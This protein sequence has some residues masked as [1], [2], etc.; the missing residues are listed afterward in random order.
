MV[1]DENYE[2]IKVY[3]LSCGHLEERERIVHVEGHDAIP[4]KS[5]YE[6]VKHTGFVKVIDSP[7]IP[8]VVEHDEVESVTVYVQDSPAD[9]IRRRRE[10]ICFPVINRGK[11]WY[12]LLTREQEDEL[13]AWYQKWL[14]APESLTEP[15]TPEWLNKKIIKTEELL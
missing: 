3:D 5:H 2:E 15:A 11:A 7:E 13:D 8:A 9:I 12:K 1:F 6:P 14:D 4:E 10:E